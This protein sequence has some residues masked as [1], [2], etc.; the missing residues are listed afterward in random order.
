[1]NFLE[2]FI[3][4]TFF[5]V[6]ARLCIVAVA[7]FFGPAL[8]SAARTA[9]ILHQSPEFVPGSV[10]LFDIYSAALYSHVTQAYLLFL[11]LLVMLYFIFHRI[12]LWVGILFLPGFAYLDNLTMNAW[13]TPPIQR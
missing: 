7:A 10:I 2:K 11:L 9:L 3:Q 4:S 5:N 12:P 1:M 13:T 8:S 6:L